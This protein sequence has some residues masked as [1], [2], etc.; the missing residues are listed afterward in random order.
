MKTESGRIETAEDFS[1]NLSHIFRNDLKMTINKY[2]I[3]ILYYWVY[4]ETH[5]LFDIITEAYHISISG[6]VISIIERGGE[7]Y[8]NHN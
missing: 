7:G 5:R 1:V 4:H 2:Q 6:N 8:Q 3:H